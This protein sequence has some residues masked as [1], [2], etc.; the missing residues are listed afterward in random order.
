MYIDDR[1]LKE[2]EDITNCSFNAIATDEKE[3]F[4]VRE[5][6]V[7]EMLDELCFR[8]RKLEEEYKDFQQNVEDNYQQIPYHRQVL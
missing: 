1:T 5:I 2:V 7:L 3:L 6:N 4:R 8:Y